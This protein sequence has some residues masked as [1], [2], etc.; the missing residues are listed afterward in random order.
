MNKKRHTHKNFYQD[1][2]DYIE[3]YFSLFDLMLE[4]KTKQSKELMTKIKKQEKRIEQRRKQSL[5]KSISFTLDQLVQKYHLNQFEKQVVLYILY[6][7][8]N[9]NE[10]ETN[11]L[12]ILEFL[13]KTRQQMIRFRSY[14]VKNSRLRRN[15]M[16]CAE[17]LD[18]KDTV[19]EVDFY[20]SEEIIA[21]LL[22]DKRKKAKKQKQE[23]RNY[24]NYLHLYF[25]MVQDL[26]KK[27]ELFSESRWDLEESSEKYLSPL[28]KQES[29]EL[30]R[31]RKN[32]KKTKK[33][34]QKVQPDAKNYPLEEI[35]RQYQL[36]E[37]DK[38]ILLI[39]LR[40][41]LGLSD[42]FMGCEGKKI[43]AIL[44]ESEKEM[45]SNRHLLY[46][47]GRLRNNKL[48]HMEKS[49]SGQNILESEYFLSEKMIRRLLGDLPAESISDE[50][51]KDY[52]EENRLFSILEPRIDLPSVIMNK[53]KKEAI[54]V[55]L[56]Q[57]K[58]HELIFKTWG[59]EEKIP[60]GKG[61]TM[62][63]SG[64]PGTGKTMM[65]EAIAK[66]LEKKLLIANYSQIQNMYVGETEKRIVSTFRKAKEEKGVLLWDEA[67]SMF[68]SRDIASQ[69]WEFRDVNIILQE[70]EK[71]EGVVI[72]TSN[73]KI[74]LDRA[75][76]RRIS[77][78]MEFSMPDMTARE[79]IWNSLLPKQIPL[80]KD[81]VIKK[82]AREYEV[83]GGIIKNAILHSARYA[84]FR[85]AKK[86]CMADLRR[87]LKM[88]EE[89]GWNRQG[90]GKIGF[91]P[92][93]QR[94]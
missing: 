27:S 81:V 28:A 20:L 62:L 35:C 88:E 14:L 91:I 89:G 41:S 13:S 54:Q 64:P 67:D 51:I 68:F 74:A 26:E 3:D 57:I 53:S 1:D 42:I 19:L 32:I 34:L 82:L 33:L 86:I 18:E 77:L 79:A 7:H 15:K 90:S 66:S 29:D 2:I 83:S 50:E 17:D 58:H 9:S 76:E 55:A 70:I 75:L 59:L 52:E 44:S 38:L 25:N 78:K 24:K 46:Q 73:R 80:D 8:F 85:G 22:G 11:G 48:I 43:L 40:D 23:E 10:L 47:G 36:V 93:T 49:R 37:N 84:A 65:A 5:K 87:G 45:I 72:L 21:Q 61:L 63:F 31:I 4:H 16:I 71:F 39:L 30:L 69:S 60:Y 56:S 12:A 94:K 92:P 6:C